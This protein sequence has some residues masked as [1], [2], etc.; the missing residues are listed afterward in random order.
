MFEEIIRNRI[1]VAFS[2]LLPFL[3]FFF[4]AVGGLIQCSQKELKGPKKRGTISSHPLFLH[5]RQT[6]EIEGDWSVDN[7]GGMDDD[8]RQA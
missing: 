8:S 7:D 1:F 2:L 6:N 5:K 4:F 3:L